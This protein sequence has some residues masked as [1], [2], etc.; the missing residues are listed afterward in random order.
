MTWV[1]WT[2]PQVVLAFWLFSQFSTWEMY[3]LSHELH[4]FICDSLFVTWNR[5]FW[6]F[7]TRHNTWWTK[8]FFS[9]ELEFPW[10]KT[11]FIKI[12]YCTWRQDMACQSRGSSKCV[13]VSKLCHLR[14]HWD[15]KRHSSVDDNNSQS[16]QS[17]CQAPPWLTRKIM[18]DKLSAVW[19]LGLR[20]NKIHL[21][22]VTIVRNDSLIFDSS[23]SEGSK[24]CVYKGNG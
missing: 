7:K 12:N 10:S 1:I 20:D 13:S 4:A 15:Q 23:H 6:T 21:F 17:S 5:I 16:V 11:L 9:C 19:Q 8:T 18:R 2:F 22:K 14:R 3:I 24:H